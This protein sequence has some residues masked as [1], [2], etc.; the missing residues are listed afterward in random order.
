MS[1]LQTSQKDTQ[2]QKQKEI[3]L[4]QAKLKSL[5]SDLEKLNSKIT[6]EET[7]SSDDTKFIGELGWLTAL[8][9][10]IVAAAA[11]L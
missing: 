6:K 3:Q 7:L 1:S 11:A 9:V 4:Q 5:Q 8:S 10:S 2:Q